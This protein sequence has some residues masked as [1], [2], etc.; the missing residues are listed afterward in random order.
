MPKKTGS[1]DYPDFT[2]TPA[3]ARKRFLK[4]LGPL[5]PR[6][7]PLN[8]KHSGNLLDLGGGLRQEKIWYDVEPGETVPAYLFT[9][10]GR[11]KRPGIVA[12]H[13][14]G[15]DN[16]F[17]I[18]KDYVCEPSPTNTGAYAYRL[19]RAGFV[20]L[21]PDS[22]CFGERREGTGYSRNF[23][24]E[25]IRTM[26]LFG[27]GSSLTWKNTWDIARAIDVMET[28]P[29]V[30]AGAIGLIGHS[31]GSIQSYIA[32]ACDQRVKATV[33]LQSFI[34][35]RHQFYSYRLCHCLYPYLPNIITAGVDYDQLV[36]S[37]VPRKIFLGWGEKDDGTPEVMTR[38]FVDAIEKES[39]RQ[40]V[41]SCV[42]LFTSPGPHDITPEMLA[43]SIAFLHRHLGLPAS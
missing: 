6:R 31:G 25:I 29:Q 8:L 10:A 39:R 42:E 27:R 28:L 2:L 34:T 37:I 9:H 23:F 35:L 32:A 20:V 38:A 33:A 13:P 22:L 19:A 3:E 16:I 4:I 26:E 30:Q 17:P 12:L 5:S 24:Y 1:A 43:A 18:G 41:E 40:K 36:A 14:H 11:S 21:A 7:T 15:G